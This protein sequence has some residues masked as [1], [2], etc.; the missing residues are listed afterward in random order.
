MLK[1]CLCEYVS[2]WLS[3]NAANDFQ[4]TETANA[5]SSGLS[6]TFSPDLG[7]EGTLTT[8][9]K[10]RRKIIKG[11]ALLVGCTEQPMVSD[12]WPFH[13]FRTNTTT[14]RPGTR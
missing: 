6:A 12:C 4:T 8:M 10:P 14:D 5:P 13:C 9:P 7:A 2:E 1:E 3:R 11:V